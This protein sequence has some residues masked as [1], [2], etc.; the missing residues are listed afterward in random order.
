MNQYEQYMRLDSYGG[1]L[2]GVALTNYA[3][4][5]T[6]VL[7]KIIAFLPGGTLGLIALNG[8]GGLAVMNLMGGVEL[9]AQSG[10][11]AAVT[12]LAYNIGKSMLSTDMQA[13]LDGTKQ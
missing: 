13:T 8:A 9:N 11:V 12:A 1:A 5:K 2:L 7:K 6:D 3:T 4:G 10:I